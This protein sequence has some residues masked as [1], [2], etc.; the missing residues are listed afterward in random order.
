MVEYSKV[1]VKLL[2][3]QLKKLKAAVKNKTRTTLRMN[4][5]MFDGNDLPHGLLLTTRQKTNIRNAFNN[6]KLTNLKLFK[7]Q[8]SKIIQSGGF[9]G[10]LLSKLAGPLM[11]I[12]IP[13]AKNVLAPLGITAAASA[14]DAGIQKKIHGSGTTTLIISNEEMND[15]MKIVQALE[16]SNILLKRVTKT[17]KNE[18]KEQKGGFLNILL[19]TLGASLLG[20]LLSRK[21]IVR[22]DS[23]NKKKEGIVRA[24]YRKEWGF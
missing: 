21:G 11:K 12:A 5:K 24:A 9:L 20:N 2:D 18:T 8:I 15:I 7:A 1:D 14:I 23:G 22:A 13:L 16:D 17:I 19:G 6:N 3:R 10:S 4:L